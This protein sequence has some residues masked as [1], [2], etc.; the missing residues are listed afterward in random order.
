MVDVGKLI[1]LEDLLVRKVT[2]F[3]LTTT[4]TPLILS[5]AFEADHMTRI[6]YGYSRLPRTL[7]H[8]D[9]QGQHSLFSSF[10]LPE[11]AWPRQLVRHNSI[12]VTWVRIHSATFFF[13]VLPFRLDLFQS[14]ARPQTF[15][16]IPKKRKTT[17][18][19]EDT[20]LL[21]YIAIFLFID[22]SHEIL[23]QHTFYSL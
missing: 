12:H 6:A 13:P 5:R 2:W 21:E 4:S 23:S 1:S 7:S 3:V 15:S 19:L 17:N 11:I 14:R 18:M 10:R 22:T 9:F 16:Q 20:F 8:F